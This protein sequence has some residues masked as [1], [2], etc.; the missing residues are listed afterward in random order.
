MNLIISSFKESDFYGGLGKALSK[1]LT[2]CPILI[3]YLY[4]KRYSNLIIKN[5]VKQSTVT[6]ADARIEDD[7][8]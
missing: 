1:F 6:V 5:S 4:S 2:L 8:K 7:L 3:V